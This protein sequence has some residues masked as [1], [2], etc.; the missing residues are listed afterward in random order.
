M[1]FV[2]EPFRVQDAHAGTSGEHRRS[3]KDTNMVALQC[4]NAVALWCFS[5]DEEAERHRCVAR[6]ITWPPAFVKGEGAL[7][8]RS[9]TSGSSCPRC[10][11]SH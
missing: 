5:A 10:I 3:Y 9:A 7:R 6:P 4:Y 8:V 1:T 2:G 11:I